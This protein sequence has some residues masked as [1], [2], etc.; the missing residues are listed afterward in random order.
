MENKYA[1]GV[2]GLGYIW[3]GTNADPLVIYKGVIFN[4]WDVEDGIATRVNE[5]LGVDCQ[6]D[7]TDAD[8]GAWVNANHKTIRAML[9]DWIAASVEAVTN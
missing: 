4:Y 9:D 1:F 6:S 5:Y 8:F 7:I 3:N 2:P